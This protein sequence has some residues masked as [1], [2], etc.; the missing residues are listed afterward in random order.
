MLTN[1]ILETKYFNQVA[2]ELR[3]VFDYLEMDTSPIQCQIS[4]ASVIYDAEV[5]EIVSS[6]ISRV[7]VPCAWDVTINV[8]RDVNGFIIYFHDRENDNH[9][10]AHD[11][12]I[13]EDDPLGKR[14]LEQIHRY[15]RS[16][17]LGK[18]KFTRFFGDIK[19]IDHIR[20]LVENIRLS[21]LHYRDELNYPNDNI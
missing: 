7:Y 19:A 16:I 8:Y 12:I 15:M 21:M 4:E 1:E 10:E 11:Y 2:L 20:T 6:S 9:I 18:V 17:Q 3:D 5:D 14:F 13:I